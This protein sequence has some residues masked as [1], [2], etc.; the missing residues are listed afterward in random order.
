MRRPSQQHPILLLLLPALIACHGKDAVPGSPHE[1]TPDLCPHIRL[2]DLDQDA[3]RRSGE[4]GQH[5]WWNFFAQDRA[6]GLGISTIFLDGNMF[7]VDY[8]VALERHRADP[9][10]HPPPDPSDYRLLQLNVHKDDRKLFSSIK[11]PPGAASEFDTARPYGRVGQSWF[12]GRQEGGERVWRVHIDSPDMFN[13]R[14]LEADLEYRDASHAFTVAHGGFFAPVP[15]GEA[16]GIHFAV[17]SPVVQGRV[18]ITDRRGRITLDEELSGG[19]HVDHIF[20]RFTC[21]LACSYYF[22]RV[23]LEG[24]GEIVYFHH[25]F[26]DPETA[27][28]GWLVRIPTDGQMPRAHAIT[29]VLES[30]PARGAFGLDYHEAIEIILDEGGTVR[31]FMERT[32]ASE[33]WP[34]QITGAGRFYVD[35]PGD[36][37]VEGAPGMAEYGYLDGLDNPLFRFLF[38]LMDRFPW[39][40]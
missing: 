14:R 8:R 13:L 35:I 23:V 24:A 30:S 22:G 26:R 1:T 4:P 34:F 28:H 17:A 5:E 36:I 6:S 29:E 12:E 25:Y 15:G 7:D 16:S 38:S 2:L 39:F 40:P 33:D 20:G 21:D 3:A 32:P 10:S 27:P 11:L 19:G 18:R 9:A 31:V 37:R